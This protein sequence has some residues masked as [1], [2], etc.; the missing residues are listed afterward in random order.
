MEGLFPH[1]LLPPHL[2]SGL[3]ERSKLVAVFDS[4]PVRLGVLNAGGGYGKTTL[5]AQVRERLLAKGQTVIWLCLDKYDLHPISVLLHLRYALSNAVEGHGKSSANE[6][7]SSVSDAL[8][9]F[10][11]DMVPLGPVVFI[12]DDFHLVGREV[13]QMFARL[14]TAAPNNARFLVATRQRGLIPLTAL[15]TAG[16]VMEIGQDDL[17]LTAGEIDSL[18]GSLVSKEAV[19]ALHERTEGWPVAVQL[20]RMW[21][22]GRPDADGRI[23]EFSGAAGDVS[24]YLT[25]QIID[26]I[27]ADI[28]DFLVS[29]S[30]VDEVN[31]DLAQELTGRDDSWA[32]LPELG[33][34][35]AVITPVE[36]SVGWFRYHALFRD[37]L[38]ARLQLRGEQAIRSLHRSAA[39]W[40]AGQGR[41]VDAVSHMCRAGDAEAACDMIEKADGIW[42]A[43]RHGAPMLKALLDNLTCE[44]IDARPRLRAARA[45]IWLKSGRYDDARLEM[46]ALRAVPRDA[47]GDPLGFARDLAAVQLSLV[48]QGDAGMLRDDVEALSSVTGDDRWMEAPCAEMLCVSMIREGN[49][50]A[51]IEAGERAVRLYED[52]ESINGRIFARLHLGLA[53]LAAAHLAQAGKV[54][55]EARKLAGASLSSDRSAVAMIDVLY[56]AWLYEKG[57]EDAAAERITAALDAIEQGEC[58]LEIYQHAYAVLL[59]IFRVRGDSAS[60]R[61][62]LERA[63]RTAQERKLAR[64]ARIV[65]ALRLEMAALEDASLE[66]YP[67]Q[68][69]SFGDASA[70]L[71]PLEREISA[72]ARAYIAL[73]NGEPEAVRKLVDGEIDA[74]AGLGRRR[75]VIKLLML[76]ALA[77]DRMGLEDES[78]AALHRAVHLAADEHVYQPFVE[79]GEQAGNLVQKAMRWFRAVNLTS[80]EV[81]LMAKIVRSTTRRNDEAAATHGNAS[82]LVGREAEVLAGLGEGLSNKHIARRLGLGEDAIKYHVKKLFA[83]LGV[84]DRA[85]AVVVAR[86]QGLISGVEG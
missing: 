81:A 22:E 82:L 4:E 68:A 34:S 50:H 26:E 3:V 61:G 28:A 17:R 29:T 12:L 83:K 55:S 46:A 21:I 54:L 51:A 75:A 37:H 7:R 39:K 43:V 80:S 5:L 8:A 63:A 27:P 73:E 45:H 72:A 20:A 6:L 44:Q 11:R 67:T 23:L 33:R 30:I 47:L 53:Y 1:K 19:T 10:V 62:V 71:T 79:T 25:E 13:H 35:S 38:S 74:C 58:W 59:K 14:I 31:G 77:L 49:V 69:I 41:L 84:S 24:N 52:F 57:D 15:K 70:A 65:G 60:G 18:V 78:S 16:A 85:M 66:S 76:K 86:Q 2:R 42:I 64:L 32:L 36:T 9:G 40:Y 56:G 48:E